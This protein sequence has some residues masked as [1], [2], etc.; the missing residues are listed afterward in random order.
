[1]TPSLADPIVTVVKPLAVMTDAQLGSASNV[2]GAALLKLL[3]IC[4]GTH[5][6]LYGSCS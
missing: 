5:R 3:C 1:M 4:G 6:L 2:A